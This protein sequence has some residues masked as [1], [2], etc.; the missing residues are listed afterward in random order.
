MKG[1]TI[2][3]IDDLF[4]SVRDKNTIFKSAELLI[5]PTSPQY[6]AVV[7]IEDYEL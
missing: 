3:I 6:F 2:V 1:W 7:K 5:A 4:L